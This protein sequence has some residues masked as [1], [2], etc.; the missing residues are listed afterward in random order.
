MRTLQSCARA[1]TRTL[2]LWLALL[3]SWHGAIAADHEAAVREL[4]RQCEATREAR[5]KPLREAEIARCIT[6]QKNDRAYCERYWRDYGNAVRLPN[7]TMRPRLFDDLPE[8]AAAY[9]AR[10]ELI[11]K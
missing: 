4:E 6:E 11:N 8:C 1:R 5:L 10:R 7:G 2:L 9:R 3:A